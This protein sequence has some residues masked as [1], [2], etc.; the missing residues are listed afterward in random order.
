MSNEV[1]SRRY[2]LTGNSSRKPRPVN[3]L[4]PQVGVVNADLEGR[5][6]P[7]FARWTAGGG[8]PHIYI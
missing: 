1:A 2:T 7:G 5:A 6:G 8:C 3:K 4:T